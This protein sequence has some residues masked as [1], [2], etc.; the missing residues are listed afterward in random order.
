MTTTEILFHLD[1]F[2]SRN[3]GSYIEISTERDLVRATL[4]FADH[5]YVASAIAASESRARELI[6]LKLSLR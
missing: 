6:D 4:R 3:P 1:G 5:V 2:L